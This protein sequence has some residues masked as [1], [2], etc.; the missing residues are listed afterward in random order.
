MELYNERAAIFEYL[1]GATRKDA[2]RAAGTYVEIEKLRVTSEQVQAKQRAMGTMA[3]QKADE[4]SKQEQ[5]TLPG[6][7]MAF[8][9]G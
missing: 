4:Q 1:G 9:G 3:K 5:I 2:E 6:F 8:G 7:E